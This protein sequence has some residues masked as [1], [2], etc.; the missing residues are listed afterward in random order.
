MTDAQEQD[1]EGQGEKKELRIE[2]KKKEEKAGHA[3]EVRGRRLKAR[4]L[5]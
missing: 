3:D 2:G 5:V 1:K 4:W